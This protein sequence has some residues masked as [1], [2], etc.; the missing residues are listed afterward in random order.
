MPKIITIGP[1]SVESEGFSV[2]IAMVLNFSK[3]ESCG[4]TPG[5]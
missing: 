1:I 3:Y 4:F 2:T 5:H